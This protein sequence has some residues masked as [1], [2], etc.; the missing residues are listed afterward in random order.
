MFQYLNVNVIGRSLQST[1]ANL[2]TKPGESSWV[3]VGTLHHSVPQF[4]HL[5]SQELSD[6]LHSAGNYIQYLVLTCNG[7]EFEKGYI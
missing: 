4:P 6:L 7:K 2:G 1:Q 3:T 5:K